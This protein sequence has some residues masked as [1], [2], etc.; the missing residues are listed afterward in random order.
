M[1]EQI[2][3]AMFVHMLGEGTR[4]L[5]ANKQLVNDLNVFPIPDGDTGDNMLMT[6]SSGFEA[7]ADADNE[8]LE[9]VVDRAAQAMLFG[10]RKT[11]S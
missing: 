2:D 6:I 7:V 5:S 3:G 1:T 10:A 9:T 11:S 8:P 4:N